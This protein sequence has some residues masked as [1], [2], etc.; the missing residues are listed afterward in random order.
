MSDTTFEGN[1][2]KPKFI[3]RG[4]TRR[5]KKSSN[6]W[7][8][9]RVRTRQVLRVG[10]GQRHDFQRAWMETD[11]RKCGSNLV[12]QKC[13]SLKSRNSAISRSILL[14]F[15]FGTTQV[16]GM[17]CSPTICIARCVVHGREV[18]S[19]SPQNVFFGNST[20]QSVGSFH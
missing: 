8:P 17:F 19:G 20:A 3:E 18:A 1:I 9:T 15:R 14:L 13:F 2:W 16:S 7:S 5:V 10:V 4:L 11:K 12:S 6:G